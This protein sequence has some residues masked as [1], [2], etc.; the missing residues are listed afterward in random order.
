MAKPYE[1]NIV[2]TYPGFAKGGRPAVPT[3]N[4]PVPVVPGTQWAEH[5][6]N[7]WYPYVNGTGGA[8]TPILTSTGTQPSLGTT[9]ISVGKF[10][11]AA[12]YFNADFYMEFGSGGGAGAGTG[13]YQIEGLPFS[14]DLDLDG[15][16]RIR[17]PVGQIA[18]FDFDTG[19]Q[20]IYSAIAISRTQLK[21]RSQGGTAVENTVPWSWAGGDSFRGRLSFPAVLLA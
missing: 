3:D 5:P 9:G 14:V 12:N 6:R 4:S 7:G 20:E 17:L 2:P 18:M 19:D 10:S 15:T 11:L 1:L 21:I 8:W 13:E 16:D